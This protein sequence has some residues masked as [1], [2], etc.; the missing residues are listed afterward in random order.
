MDPQGG[1]DLSGDRTDWFNVS[2]DVLARRYVNWIDTRNG[3]EANILQIAPNTWGSP[4]SKLTALLLAG[5][6]DKEG[7]ARAALDP[8]GLTRIFTWIDLNVPY[9]R[10]YEMEDEH[11][12]GG[13]RVYPAGLAKTLADVWSKRCA[14][15]H[16]GKPAAPE[17]V[18][19]T[20]PELNPFLAAPLAKSAGGRGACKGEVFRS[21]EDPDY[22]AILRTFDP[23]QEALKARPRMDM[24]GAVPDAHVKRSTL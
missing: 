22:Q 5:H 8:D 1:V 11:R 14:E 20:S 10:T 23:V 7:K 17:F 9:Y 3:N 21:K 15:C 2:Y 24:D 4:R 19:I 12:E 13:R 16:K 18:R 6:P